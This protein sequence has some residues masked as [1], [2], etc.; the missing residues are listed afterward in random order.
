MLF[1]FIPFT[2]SYHKSIKIQGGLKEEWIFNHGGDALLKSCHK[3]TQIRE[4]IES[5]TGKI[6]HSVTLQFFCIYIHPLHN[7]IR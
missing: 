4:L 5:A 3:E 6:I 1:S 2:I 7:F